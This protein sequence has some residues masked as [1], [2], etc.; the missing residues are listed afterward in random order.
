MTDAKSS[1]H[2]PRRRWPGWLLRAALLLFA[3]SVF[4][5]APRYLAGLD[6]GQW[7]LWLARLS[8]VLGIVALVGVVCLLGSWFCKRRGG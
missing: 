7:L 2:A 5:P 8:W 3:A 6:A 4:T 1:P